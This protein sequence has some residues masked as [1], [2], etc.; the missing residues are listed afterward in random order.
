MGQMELKM[1]ASCP[2]FKVETSQSS[3]DTFATVACTEVFE[4][5]LCWR[6]CHRINPRC[7]PAL[8]LCLCWILP[9]IPLTPIWDLPL[10]LS[11]VGF[12]D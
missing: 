11:C 12:A 7:I 9:K 2:L 1:H 3:L 8:K 4:E 6:E 5:A 10:L